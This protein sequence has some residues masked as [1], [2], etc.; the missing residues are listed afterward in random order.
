M[1]TCDNCDQECVDGY[2]V[3][4]TNCDAKRDRRVESSELSDALSSILTKNGYSVRVH[5]EEG[6]L[7]VSYKKPGSWMW[8]R[9]A[10]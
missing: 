2:V 7:D 3:L 4:C 8:R 5:A 6:T 9:I 1:I 10:K